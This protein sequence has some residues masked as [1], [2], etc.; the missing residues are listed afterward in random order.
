MFQPHTTSVSCWQWGSRCRVS[1]PP[2]RVD[3]ECFEESPNVYYLTG[4]HFHHEQSSRS[5]QKTT[6]PPLHALYSVQKYMALKSTRKQVVGIRTSGPLAT[7]LQHLTACM[8][9]PPL[10]LG[11][12]IGYRWWWCTSNECLPTSTVKRGSPC[13]VHSSPSVLLML[14]RSLHVQGVAGGRHKSSEISSG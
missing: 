6:E 13:P 2:F 1:P 5:F 3:F 14:C 12:K 8:A 9:P 11:S 10:E 7:E 4:R